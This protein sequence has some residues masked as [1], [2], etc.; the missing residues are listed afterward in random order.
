MTAAGTYQVELS[1]AAAEHYDI[2]YIP[3]QFTI[4]KRPLKVTAYNQT[5]VNGQVQTLNTTLYSIEEK[6]GEG[7]ASTDT[8][9][10]VFKLTTTITFG[11]DGKVTSTSNGTISIA[12]VGGAASKWA[13]YDTTSSVTGTATVIVGSTENPAVTLDDTATLVDKYAK[14]EDVTGATVT[15]SSR[16]LNAEN[17]NVLVLPFDVTV[18]ALSTA[19]DYAVVDVL[20]QTASDGNMH[21]KLAVTGTIAANTPFMIYPTTTYNNLNQVKFTGVTIKKDA[22]KNA[23]VSVK[24]GSNNKLVGT[25]AETNI[26]GVKFYGMQGGTWG[27]LENFTEASPATVKPL[28]AYIDMSEATAS[29]PIIYIEEPDGYTTAIKTLDVETM[30]TYSTDGWYNLNGVK[31]NGVPTEKGIYINNGKKVVIK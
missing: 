9:E 21:F 30:N 29:A 12:D 11:D 22:L 15:F 26:Y 3:S 17:W 16:N 10:E 5:F 31:L 14:T 24:D 1:G 7:L 28:R 20:D 13:N 19:F 25:Y 23:T 18:K 4:T 8:A 2:S 27:S 6:D